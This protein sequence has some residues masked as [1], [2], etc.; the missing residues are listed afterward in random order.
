VGIPATEEAAMATKTS[1]D[2][3]DARPQREKTSRPT[4]QRGQPGPSLTSQQ[5]WQTIARA[6]FA[7]LSFVTPTGEPRSSGVVYKT[8][9]RRLCVAV[10]PDS[11]K[12]KHVAAAGR[13]A[14]T[15][16]VRRGGALSLLTPIPPATISFQASAIVHP[17]GSPQ[18]KWLLREL[19]SRI[20]AERR[21]SGSV[22]EVRPEGTFLT[23]G[24][25]VP[26]LKMLDP[27]AALARV[28][29]I[30]PSRRQI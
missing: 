5:V 8:V 21:T 28:P 23:Y 20:P 26:L 22:I 7:V 30:P 6:S 27:A 11:W 18:A 19:A 17:S 25:G 13:V 24:L 29:V 9:G 10:E 14:M 3:A 12:A 1:H 4:P 2:A 16:P 15:V